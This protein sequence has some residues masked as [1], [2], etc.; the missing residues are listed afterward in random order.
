M[1]RRDWSNMGRAAA[2]ISLVFM[3]ALGGRAMAGTE[4]ISDQPAASLL[5]PYF[6]VNLANRSAATTLLSINNSSATAIL[7][8]VVIWSDL[9][10]PVLQF[11]V[12]LTG[13]DVYHFN[14]QNLLM[15][16]TQPQTASAG[17]DPTDNISPKGSLSQDINFASCTGVLPNPP[18][19]AQ[20]L[21][22]LQNALSG[23]PAAG[24]GGKCAG[25]DHGDRVARGYITVDT[26]NNCTVRFPSDAGY[27]GAGGTG[28][29][30]NQNVLWGDSFYI[31]SSTHHAVAQSLVSIIASATDTATSTAGRYT[32]YGRYDAFTAVDNRQP[33]STSFAARYVNPNSPDGKR[34][35]SA[36][37]AMIVWRDSKVAQAPFTCPATLGSTPSWYGLG[38]EGIVIFDE[39]EHPQ[40]PA[41]CKI[42]PCPP[43]AALAPFAAETQKIKVGASALPTSFD[44]GWMYLDLNSTVAAA[45]SNPPV[46]PAAAQAWV[47]TLFNNGSLPYQVGARAIMLDSATAANHFVP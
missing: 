22:D 36:G 29:A 31:N 19:T 39:Q 43:S 12:Y 6:E 30:T 23:K 5:L 3:L 26:V 44:A 38:Q 4:I 20:Q 17:Q 15:F 13:Y 24:L 14:L 25:V 34:Y 33:L 35:F 9:S 46:D 42:P 47:I 27:F 28:D 45:G 21:A 7:A 18:L 11:N 40:V 2:A 41:V 16:G 1:N 10:V 32:F 37:T 8:H